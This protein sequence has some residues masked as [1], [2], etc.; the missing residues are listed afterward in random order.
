MLQNITKNINLDDKINSLDEKN[1][2]ADIN[3]KIDSNNNSD[4]L[5]S[6]IDKEI[7]KIDYVKDKVTEGRKYNFYE[8]LKSK[9]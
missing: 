2:M 6:L 5:N 1:N 3:E 4:Q 7:E 9:K 8:G